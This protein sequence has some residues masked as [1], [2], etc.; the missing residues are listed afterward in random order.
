MPNSRFPNNSPQ[1]YGWRQGGCV[2]LFYTVYWPNWM[3]RDV[4]EY[5]FNSVSTWC[6]RQ[7][8]GVGGTSGKKSCPSSQ[9]CEHLSTGV[10]PGHWCRR[11]ATGHSSGFRLDLCSTS[12][13]FQN[14]KWQKVWVSGPNSWRFSWHVMAT[15]VCLCVSLKLLWWFR[16]NWIVSP[17]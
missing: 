14:H 3:H 13:P 4:K 11:C 2:H 6:S 8:V 7:R 17:L 5:S 12:R 1:T 15:F 10:W 9:H 16:K